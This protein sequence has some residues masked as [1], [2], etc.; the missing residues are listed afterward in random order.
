MNNVSAIVKWKSK[1]RNQYNQVNYMTRNTNS[2]CDKNTREHNMQVNQEVSIFTA[3]EHEP[4]RNSKDKNETQITKK[5]HKRGTEGS[6][7]FKDTGL[8]ISSVM[9]QDP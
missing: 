4:S 2:E 6:N 3:G 8:T 5:I 9:D 7:M 1:I